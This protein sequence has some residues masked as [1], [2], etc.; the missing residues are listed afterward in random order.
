MSSLYQE[1]IRR[2]TEYAVEKESKNIKPN[3]KIKVSIT[4]AEEGVIVNAKKIKKMSDEA[5][6]TLLEKYYEEFLVETLKQYKDVDKAEAEADKLAN[7]KMEK[8]Q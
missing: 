1:A 8:E 2:A 3:E 4:V 5:K 7:Q 6:D